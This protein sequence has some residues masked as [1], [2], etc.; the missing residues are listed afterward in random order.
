MGG[1]SDSEREA[2][3]EEQEAASALTSPSCKGGVASWVHH[4]R[5]R[6]TAEDHSAT[7][8]A[9]G[10][11]AQSCGDSRAHSTLRSCGT[12]L[13]TAACPQDRFYPSQQRAAIAL[14][15]ATATVDATR[16]ACESQHALQ[17]PADAGQ[18]TI[19]R[20]HAGAASTEHTRHARC[21]LQR[22]RCRFVF[23]RGEC[24]RRFRSCF[25]DFHPN[26]AA[27]HRRS[28][29]KKLEIRV[30]AKASEGRWAARIAAAPSDASS[31]PTE[32]ADRIP[33]GRSPIAAICSCCIFQCR[34]CCCLSCGCCDLLILCCCCD[35]RVSGLFHSCC[36]LAE[37]GSD[38]VIFACN[39]CGYCSTFCETGDQTAASFRHLCSCIILNC[40]GCS[41]PSLLPSCARCFPPRLLFLPL[42]LRSDTQHSRLVPHGRSAPFL[43]RYGGSWPI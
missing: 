43:Q 38:R 24:A 41:S 6:R 13:S 10:G 5:H 29:A 1:A 30:E 32:D 14:V 11:R 34:R 36:P 15:A 21:R 22:H 18:R 7:T 3:W 31:T 42:L 28:R 19:R 23:G 9:W 25:I 2:E 35:L 39:S 37:A 12:P 4:A 40:R 27:A 26:S 20:V 33:V 8:V 17:R 16:S